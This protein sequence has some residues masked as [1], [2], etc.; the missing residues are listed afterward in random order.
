MMGH[1]VHPWLTI[2]GLLVG[3]VAFG[4]TPLALAWLWARVFSPNKP[5]AE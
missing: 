5:G 1:A 3:A 4:F 2:V